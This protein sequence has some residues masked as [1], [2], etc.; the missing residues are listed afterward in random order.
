MFNIEGVIMIEENSLVIKASGAISCT[1]SGTATQRVAWNVLLKNAYF[2][3][4]KE[5]VHSIKLRDLIAETNYNHKDLNEFK[6]ALKGLMSIVVEWNIIGRD[7]DRW[8]ATTLLAGCELV[9]GVFEYSFSPQ[10]KKKLTKPNIYAKISMAVQAR[11][12]KSSATVTLYENILD[13]YDFK[14]NVSK[15]PWVEVQIFKKLLGIA[16]NAY[17]AYKD[18]KKRVI[19]PALNDI[20]NN[21]QFNVELATK[22]K[23]RKIS[24]LR[25]NISL[26]P[27]FYLDPYHQNSLFEQPVA[28]EEKEIENEDLLNE[29]IDKIGLDRDT[30]ITLIKSVDEF[31]ITEKMNYTLK[32]HYAGKIKSTL[33]G[34]FIQAIKNNWSVINKVEEESKK[35]QEERERRLAEKRKLSEKIQQQAH[36]K[37]EL[38]RQINELEASEYEKLEALARERLEGKEG[39]ITYKAMFCNT[40]VDIYKE[41]HSI[42]L[43][44]VEK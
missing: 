32:Q 3:L 28:I 15:A 20:Q 21:T 19:T 22:K 35:Q 37:T 18:L 42:S 12:R 34:Y 16:D 14:R 6:Q 38:K 43:C 29:L 44:D 25:F 9:N 30:A 4:R 41:I 7:E 2:S 5:E 36:E 31:E 33:G 1:H 24:H 10:L 11:L 8:G 39:L 23:G 27:E 40:V 26:K 13:W 17:P